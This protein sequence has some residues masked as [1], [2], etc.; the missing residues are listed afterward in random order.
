MCHLLFQLSEAE[1]SSLKTG[2]LKLYQQLK[3]HFQPEEDLPA[4]DRVLVGLI[5]DF[6]KW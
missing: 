4:S 3:R 1:V 5:K 6:C 2:D